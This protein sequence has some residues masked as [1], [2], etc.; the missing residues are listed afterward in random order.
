[1]NRKHKKLIRL[2]AVLLAVLL[3]LGTV[4]S[5]ILGY[6]YGEEALSVGNNRQ[7]L[8]M[9]Y[10]EEEQALR[11]SQRLVYT[12]TS[13]KDLDR[14][15]FYASANLFR[16]KSTLPYEG[17]ILNDAFP[18]GYLPGGIE[19]STVRVNG[20]EVDWGYQGEGE[21]YL[22][23]SC[24][25]SPGEQCAFEFD[26]Y[27]L[28]TENEA[29][30]GVSSEGWQLSNFYFTPASL[31][32]TGE[33]IL[34]SPLSWTRY[35][36]TPA[37]DFEAHIILPDTYLLAATGTESRSEASNHQ[38][39]WNISAKNVHDFSLAFGRRYR[40]SLVETDSGIQLRCLTNVRGAEKNVLQLALEAV[41]ICESWWGP[42]PF[43]Q[44]D[45][46]QTGCAT[47]ALNHSACLWLSEDL[48]SKNSEELGQAIRRFIAQ[49]YFGFSAYSHP[50]SDAWLSD[51]I[52]EYL[53]YLMLE[54]TGGY[55]TYI[56]ALNKNVVPSLQMT[57]PGGLNV[58]S[59]AS[60]FTPEEY[61]IVVLD[62]GAA[63]F[64]ELYTAMGREDLLKGLSL[65]YQ[66]GKSVD[67]LSE[68]DLVEALDAA[69][70]KSWEAFLTDWVFNIGDY[71]NQSIDWL[72]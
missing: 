41:E 9:E 11:M 48:L 27:L 22:R 59:E 66:K 20:N 15:I 13:S 60:L 54:E 38:I 71:V 19:L 61:K 18:D 47:A 67:V 70:G 57:I 65:F 2:L 40:E 17:E 16:R 56:A 32:E 7:I 24:E 64:H 33:F 50:S 31:N 35:I 6:A 69:S 4:V 53:S 28:L 42:L 29:F 8:T 37:A 52:C 5:V 51:S 63:V 55:E 44:L 25:L 39:S 14:V 43:D 58:A 46:V 12:N 10:L 26:Y 1:M 68:M 21:N 23:V 3:I 49:Q 45:F 62:R 72:S 34:N 36:D 30:S